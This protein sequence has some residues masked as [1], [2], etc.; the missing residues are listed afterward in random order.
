MEKIYYPYPAI[1]LPNQVKRFT[2]VRLML[3]ILHFIRMKQEKIDTF[4][5]M[6]KMNLNFG[7]NQE[8][9]LL[10]SGVGF[11]SGPIQPNKKHTNILRNAFYNIF[12]F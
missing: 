9:T 8:L 6:R 3:L 1:L 2:L 5:A 11:T 12:F 7:I 10:R 4:F